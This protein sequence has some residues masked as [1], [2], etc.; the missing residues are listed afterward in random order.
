VKLTR[1]FFERSVVEVAP[2][3]LGCRLIRELDDGTRLEGRIVEVE[4]YLGDGTDPAAHSHR[5]ATT[6]NRSMFGP[7]GHFYVYRSMGLHHCINLVCE[8]S[9]R[10]AAVLVRALEPLAGQARMAE[11]RG[12]PSG[13]GLANGPGKLCQAFGIGLEHDGVDALAGALRIEG[14]TRAEKARRDETILAGPR[15]GISRAAELP[16]RYF[17]AAHP[18]V[19][20]S[21]LNGRARPAALG[22]GD[23]ERVCSAQGIALEK[24]PS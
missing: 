20:R 17:L 22:G 12:V 10:G 9:G 18:C 16:Y 5:G 23:L 13:P 21:P 24:P 7:P 19:T 6:R 11:L 2:E 15:I 1:R 3:L 4:A 8:P 14:P